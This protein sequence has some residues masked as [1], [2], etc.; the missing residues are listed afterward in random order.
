MFVYKLLNDDS[1]VIYVGRTDNL[2]RRYLSHKKGISTDFKKEF[3]KMEYIKIDSMADLIIYEILY[4]NL[5]K[6]IYNTTSRTDDSLSTELIEMALKKE[7][8]VFNQ[9]ESISAM[10]I[11]KSKARGKY[12]PRNNDKIFIDKHK[13]KSLCSCK[14]VKVKEIALA[15]GITA[16]TLSKYLRI[17]MSEEIFTQ[18]CDFLNCKPG[19]I[20]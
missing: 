3:S 5:Y 2:K 6:P 17:G 9:E 8:K 14:R 18:V 4:I 10:D 11:V 15:V 12:K 7:W 20:V 1:K 19:E 16:N 13:F